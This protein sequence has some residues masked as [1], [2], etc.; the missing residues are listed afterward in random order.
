MAL[1]EEAPIGQ[2]QALMLNGKIT[3]RDLVKHFLGRIEKFDHN[4]PHINSVVTVNENAIG[5]AEKLDAYLAGEGKLIGPLHGVPFILKDQIMTKGIR[6]TF[7]SIALRDFVPD[8]DATIVTRIREAG[9]IILAKG[10]MPDF[11]V[12]WYGVSSVEG[13]TLNP[14]DISRDPGGSS[15]GVAA[16]VSAG[17]A[18]VGIGED[19]AGS[20]R[21]P[22]SFNSLF[23]IRVTT[24]LISRSG[25]CPIVNFQDTPG[26]LAR[27][28][29]DLAVVLDVIIGYDGADPQSSVNLL[30][31]PGSGYLAGLRGNVLKGAKIGILREA[32]PEE[33]EQLLSVTDDAI[34]LIEEAGAEF[35]DPII[36]S[37]LKEK[38]SSSGLYDVQTKHDVNAFLSSIDIEGARSI[39]QIVADGKYHKLVD[40]LEGIA[41]GVDIPEKHN[42]YFERRFAQYR[43]REEIMETLANEGIDAILYP[44]ARIPPPLKREVKEKK[45]KGLGF[46]VNSFLASHSGCPAVAIPAGFTKEGL[47][48]G[49]ELLGAPFSEQKLLNLALSFQKVA[50][51]R[52]PPSITHEAD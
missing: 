22:A 52:K 9:G 34:K 42:E 14:Y 13:H 12:S 2:V 17:F 8:K 21:V 45:W 11:G 28:V 38:L 23:G 4:G 20:I 36:I 1:L 10:N 25:M 43:L 24:G 39:E 44:T 6:T 51:P 35:V 49:I 46:P 41:L 30:N 40:I 29:E 31:R 26:P 47:P 3:S 18:T 15:S 19:T 27:N 48:I 16:A 50:G 37:N 5:D 33:D 32:F 7:G